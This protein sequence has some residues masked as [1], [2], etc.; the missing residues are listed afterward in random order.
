MLA[1]VSLLIFTFHLFFVHLGPVT[2]CLSI[3]FRNFLT[4]ISSHTCPSLLPLSFQSEIPI[5]CVLLSDIFPKILMLSS[6]I[7]I[8]TFLLLSVQ[9]KFPFPY[10]QVLLRFCGSLIEDS[11]NLIEDSLHL[12]YHCF[13]PCHFDCYLQFP[14][15]W[16]Y[17]PSAFACCLPFPL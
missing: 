2:W 15:L 11:D 14:C 10:L 9:F 12:C 17:H 16:R 7:F 3:F 4:D 5:T 6:L 1:V 13:K 8:F